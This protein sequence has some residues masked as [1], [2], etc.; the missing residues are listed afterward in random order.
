MDNSC[1]HCL[2]AAA[3]HTRRIDFPLHKVHAPVSRFVSGV[4]FVLLHLELQHWNAKN[5]STL[6]QVHYLSPA[7]KG[8]LTD[9][10]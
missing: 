1:L 10:L 3:M 5:V 9:N 6:L 8:R 2:C 7:L 4:T